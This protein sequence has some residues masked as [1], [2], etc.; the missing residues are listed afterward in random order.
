MA[1]AYEREAIR[2]HVLGRFADMLLAAR[3]HP[4]MLVYL[5]NARSIGPNSVAGIVRNR[6]LNENLAREILE[7]HTLGV[8]TGYT[9]ADVTSF[10]KVI[11][12]W[13]ILPTADNPEHG[14]EFVFNP[15]M[16]EPGD[17]DADRARPIRQA[18]SSRDAACSPTW[19]AIRR[20]R[21]TSPPSSR[22]ISSPT[23]RPRARRCGS[24]F[25]FFETEGDLKEVA[26]ALVT[27]PEAWAAERAKIKRPSEWLVATR[28]AA[29][30][31]NARHPKAWSA[32]KG[33]S[34][35]SC[36]SR[37]RR[38]ATRTTNAAWLDGLEQRLESAN[39]FAQ[40]VAADVDPR[41]LVET[42][43]GPLATE[44]YA[45]GR[46]ARREPAQA[47]TLLI[48]APEFQRR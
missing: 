1:G 7:L 47:L 4:A 25:R 35:S 27:A 12:G 8:R 41:E 9:Q 44:R 11:T 29:G 28:R 32:S 17:A 33:C 43:L 14:G 45:A 46:R 20:P 31:A 21:S 26:R 36:G 15:R 22:A 5:D 38:R 39:A 3:G 13:T 16:H 2:P 18:A 19:R 10:A 6:G 30:R 37:R 42:T 24:T 34:A 48:M 23:S 40:A